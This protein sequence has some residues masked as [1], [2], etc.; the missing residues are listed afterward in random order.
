MDR[1]SQEVTVLLRLC[2]ACQ[3]ELLETDR[4]CRR[5]GVCQ[6]TGDLNGDEPAVK[7]A[8]GEP[9]QRTAPALSADEAFE[10]YVT[11]DGLLLNEAVGYQTTPFA[12]EKSSQ[13]QSYRRVSG[14]LVNALAASVTDNVAAN[15][16]SRLARKVIP[17]IILIPIWLIIILLS[18]LDAYATAKMLTKQVN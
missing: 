12:Q 3:A 10:F 14:S 17:A 6:Q 13:E 4:F 5:C 16:N 9:L 7:K 8:T 1:I 18:P 11:G 15:F 2:L